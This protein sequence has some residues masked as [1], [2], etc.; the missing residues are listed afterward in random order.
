L[1]K[2]PILHLQKGDIL[3]SVNG[4]SLLGLTHAQAVATL[5]STVERSMVGLGLLEGPETSVGSH[6]FIPSWLYWQK[7][8]R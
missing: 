4:T 2:L 1:K 6:N 7:L 3:L 8:P 5:K